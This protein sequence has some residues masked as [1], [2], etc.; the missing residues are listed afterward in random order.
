M[1]GGSISGFP[2]FCPVTPSV[3]SVRAL[4]SLRIVPGYHFSDFQAALPTDGRHT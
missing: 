2:I 3:F 4:L 1:I